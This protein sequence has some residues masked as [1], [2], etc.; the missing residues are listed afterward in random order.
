MP[1]IVRQQGHPMRRSLFFAATALSSFGVY[2]NIVAVTV[3]GHDYGIGAGLF[4]LLT[5]LC[6]WIAYGVMGMAWIHEQ[7]IAKFWPVAGTS[8]GLLALNG[9]GTLFFSASYSPLVMVVPAIVVSPAIA[10][11]VWMV[12]YHLANPASARG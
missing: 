12:W 9:G 1:E 11:A 4:F 3:V 6:A 7:T 5:S 10:M 8:A 2:E